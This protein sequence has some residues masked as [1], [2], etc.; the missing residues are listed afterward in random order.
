[1]ESTSVPE[2]AAIQIEQRW[3]GMDS[4]GFRWIQMDL[5]GFR[6]IQVDLDGF[7]WTQINSD[8]EYICA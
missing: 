3:F 1:M 8:G 5:D 4:D 7:R 2:Q 6:W